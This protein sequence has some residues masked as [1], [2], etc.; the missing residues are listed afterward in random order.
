[1]KVNKEL[2]RKDSKGKRGK[3]RKKLELREEKLNRTA[4]EE[5]TV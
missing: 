5:Q 2:K 1:M 3:G 4:N